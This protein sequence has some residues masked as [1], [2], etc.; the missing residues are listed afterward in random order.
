MTKVVFDRLFRHLVKIF[1][2]VYAE[3]AQRFG[4]P[5]RREK[6]A[7]FGDRLFGDGE[8]MLPLD[9]P[10]VL[11]VGDELVERFFRKY[12]VEPGDRHDRKPRAVSDVVIGAEL[13]LDGVA[14]PG[15][16]RAA[17][18]EPVYRERG[19][20]HEVGAG[21][22]I[23][24]SDDRAPAVFDADF[25]QRFR[26]PVLDGGAMHVGKIAFE[27]M[28]HDVRNARRGLEAGNGEG[29]C[30]IED[31]GDGFQKFAL[32]RLFL[33]ERHVGDDRVAVHLAAR[34]R[35]GEDGEEGQGARYVV[36]FDH[37]PK[38]AFMVNARGDGFAAVDDR[39]AAQRH[40]RLD[41]VLLA[42]FDA[43]F[44]RGYLGIGLNAVKLHPFYP[45]AL[46][47]LGERAVNARAFDRAAARGEQDFF[48]DRGD[49]LGKLGYLA[50]AE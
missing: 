4:Q 28:A 9:A 3:S 24:G 2:A 15:V 8:G 44:D 22:V 39:A 32:D 48:A 50:F 21:G 17:A 12:M 6:F 25:E 29:V 43:L 42:K 13:M 26:D 38:V 18:R 33:V 47:K 31:G 11:A 1:A 30:G 40:D 14:A 20:P 41:L 23:G 34:R 16:A 45:R 5:E 37:L 10:D 36:V 46:Q 7:R 35:H 27:D 49:M 19:R